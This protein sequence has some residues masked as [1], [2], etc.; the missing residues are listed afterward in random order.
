MNI[1]KRLFVIPLFLKLKR[2]MNNSV[3]QVFY[4]KKVRVIIVAKLMKITLN[5]TRVYT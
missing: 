1:L 2:N 4:L 5:I 3:L